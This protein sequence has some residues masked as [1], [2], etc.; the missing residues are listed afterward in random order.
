MWWLQI[1]IICLAIIF[2]FR[3]YIDWRRGRC[4]TKAF[5]GWSLVWVAAVVVMLFPWT[6]DFVARHIGS[7]SGANW[8]VYLCVIALFYMTFRIYIMIEELRKNETIIIRKIALLSEKV[9]GLCELKK[10][11]ADIADER[12]Q[13]A[14]GSVES[15]SNEK[16]QLLRKE[17]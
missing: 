7:G 4:H 17:E 16:E 8:V 10:K 6:T 2:T 1:L 11:D 9:N 3:T 5:L 15:V 12:L 13:S 14:A